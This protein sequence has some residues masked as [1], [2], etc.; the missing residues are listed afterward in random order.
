MNTSL[1]SHPYLLAEV[2]KEGVYSELGDWGG[3]GYKIHSA[4]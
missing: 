1:N 2:T 3:G 4:A